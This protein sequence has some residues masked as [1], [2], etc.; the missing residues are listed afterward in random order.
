MKKLL[1][2]VAACVAALT[3]LPGSA[4]GITGNYVPD[5]EHPFVG[6]VAFYDADGNFMWRCSG[7]LLTDRVFLTAGH[8]TDQDA[9]ESPVMARIWFEQDVGGQYNPP[10][11]PVDPRTGYP[12]RCIEGDP[13]CVTSTLL[14]DF[15]FDNF[16]GFPN[17]HD[18][19]LIILPED[20]AVEL[21]EYG[22]LAPAGFLDSLSADALKAATF[23]VAGYGVSRTNPAQTTSF[24]QR[25]MALTKLTNPNL[26]ASRNTA[27]FNLQLSSAPGGGR[28]G[29]CFG[30]SG[31]P[32]FYGDYS[33]NVIVGV[34]SWLFGFNRQTCGGTGFAFRTDTEA[35]I[36]WILGIVTQYAPSEVAEI[37]FAG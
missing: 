24:R 31:G 17:I 6:L 26:N 1:L 14:F 12:D 30:D 29:T 37:Q 28:G 16:A 8:C 9:E 36:N 15:G 3:V 20:Q 10:S 4:R 22:V 35:V 7:S 11:V 21:P 2:L 13:L 33:S 32:T 27:G 19:G 23:T 34:N 18:V 5:N 25:L